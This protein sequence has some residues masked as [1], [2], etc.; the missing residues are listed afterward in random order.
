MLYHSWKGM[1]D[2]HCNNDMQE[3]ATGVEECEKHKISGN[4]GSMCLWFAA[5]T[6]TGSCA[7]IKD[8]HRGNICSSVPRAVRIRVNTLLQ[9]WSEDLIGS[10]HRHLA[11][12][13]VKWDQHPRIWS[14]TGFGIFFLMPE[15][16][17]WEKVETRWLSRIE[18]SPE[19]KN[20]KEAQ[21]AVS[22]MVI[23]SRVSSISRKCQSVTEVSTQV[24]R[25]VSNVE[26]HVAVSQ[27]WYCDRGSRA[28]VSNQMQQTARP[29]PPLCSTWW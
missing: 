24:P 29:P 6:Y 13:S 23:L 19:P 1:F 12:W 16:K 14:K 25:R 10:N 18:Q 11:V 15:S 9:V 20:H 5:V 27:Q 4:G 7:I 22:M 2:D 28:C 17:P 8:S 21:A 3:C 26:E